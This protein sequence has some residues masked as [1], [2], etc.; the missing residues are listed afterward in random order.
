MNLAPQGSCVPK[1]GGGATGAQCKSKAAAM[2][3]QGTEKMKAGIRA[4]ASPNAPPP[5]PPFPSPLPNSPSIALRHSQLPEESSTEWASAKSAVDT[6]RL[7]VD[8]NHAAATRVLFALVAERALRARGRF[9]LGALRMRGGARRP[10][11]FGGP[12][13]CGFWSSAGEGPD[14]LPPAQPGSDP[15]PRA[16]QRARCLRLRCIPLCQG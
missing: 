13:S 8:A 15:R 12:R 10:R 14:P 6:A 7:A 2:E 11:G 3:D 1:D 16:S 4:H 5:W 9:L